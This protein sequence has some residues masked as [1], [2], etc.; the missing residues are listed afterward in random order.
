V[1]VSGIRVKSV[2]TPDTSGHFRTLSGHF[3]MAMTPKITPSKETCSSNEEGITTEG[4]ERE[5]G[6]RGRKTSN[7]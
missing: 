6:E 7:F 3:W 1:K 5:E 4:A 2:R